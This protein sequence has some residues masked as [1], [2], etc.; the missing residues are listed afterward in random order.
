ME[1]MLYKLHEGWEWRTVKELSQKVQYGHTTKAKSSGNAKF[2]RITDIQR[3]NINWKKVPFVSISSK[4][5]AKYKLQTNDLVFARSEATSGKSIL[6]RNSPENAIF[7]SYLIRIIPS[8]KIILPEFLALFF[9]SPIYWKQVAASAS[10]A[11]QPNINGTKLSSFNVPLPSL[12]RQERIV[13]KL[14]SLIIRIDTAIN[15][16]QDNLKLSKNLFAS[17]LVDSFKSNPRWR[18]CTVKDIFKVINGRAYKKAELLDSG[19]YRVV[20]IQNLKGGMSYYYSNLE[21]NEDKYCS[22]GDLLFSWSG[23]PGTSFGAFI[24]DGEKSIYHYHIWKMELLGEMDIRFAYWLLRDLTEEA[25]S[26]SRGV[27]GMLHITKGM[28]ES[29]EIALPPLIEQQKIATKL[30]ALSRQIRAIEAATEE[31]LRDLAAL[32][33][34]LLDNAFRG[35]L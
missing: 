29:F 8:C 4:D 27:A 5:L 24:W 6:I 28:M 17:A 22:R 32:K 35:Q 18:S 13:D 34:S 3:G 12:N 14:N 15:H 20:R 30:D 2:L 23:T 33:S 21:L 9:Q 7:A 25:I 16:L 26:K 31:K 19:K 11:A 1:Q 10:G